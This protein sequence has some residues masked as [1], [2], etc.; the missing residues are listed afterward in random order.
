MAREKRKR[1]RRWWPEA[2]VQELIV[3]SLAG[4]LDAQR[5]LCEH[6]YRLAATSLDLYRNGYAVEPEDFVQE[7][8]S[9]C[10]SKIGLYSPERGETFSYF[11]TAIARV[12]SEMI[13][14]RLRSIYPMGR[15]AG[16]ALGSIEDSNGRAVMPQFDDL[17]CD[18][19][20]TSIL[21]DRLKNQ[22][23]HC[24]RVDF[25]NRATGGRGHQRTKA[26]FDRQ[27]RA[28][29][30]ES[31]QAGVG[32]GR[33]AQLLKVDKRRIRAAVSRACIEAGIPQIEDPDPN[34]IQT[35]SE[36]EA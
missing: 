24:C 35:K 22:I 34:D 19:D 25:L 36:N 4:K 18:D 1:R 30:L 29:V 28:S 9:H 17:T 16:H 11:R 14:K 20:V 26:R 23:T 2:E 33:I 7:A 32:F 5:T 3:Q 8:A 6:F 12:F 13:G 21:P 15:A 27:S 31:V 10:Y